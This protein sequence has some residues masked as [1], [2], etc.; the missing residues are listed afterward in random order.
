[1]YDEP[2]RERGGGANVNG[3]ALKNMICARKKH[4]PKS[5]H[6]LHSSVN[7]IS[8]RGMPVAQPEYSSLRVLFRTGSAKR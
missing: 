2:V 8:I 3:V 6:C 4:M 5:Q 1:M 7:T